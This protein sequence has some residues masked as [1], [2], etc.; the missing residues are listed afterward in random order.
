MFDIFLDPDSRR[1]QKIEKTADDAKHKSRGASDEVCVLSERLDRLSLLCQAMWE[2]L[3]ERTNISEEQLYKKIEQVDL[4]D[5]K[6]DGK[7]EPRV[8]SC[9]SCGRKVSGQHG[10]CVYCGETIRPPETFAV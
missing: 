6:R 9:K 2:L 4:R 5:G 8:L 10:R 7:M 3:R 1:F